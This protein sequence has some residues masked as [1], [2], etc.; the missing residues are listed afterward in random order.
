MRNIS[1][2]LIFL[3]SGINA[4]AQENTQSGIIISTNINDHFLIIDDDFENAVRITEPDTIFLDPGTYQFRI[5]SPLKN[6]FV[7]SENIS[8]N[9]F[10]IKQLNL[11][12]SNYDPQFSSYPLLYWDSNIIVFS[13][14]NADIYL[15][16]EKVGLTAVALKIPSG[17]V[18]LK[19]ENNSLSSIKNIYASN[20][21]LQVINLTTL[22]VKKK[23]LT[24]SFIPG[25]SQFYK[26]QK[27]KGGLLAAGFLSF[28]TTSIIFN[29]KFND[30]ENDY[31]VFRTFY[32]S[33][34]DPSDVLRYARLAEESLDDSEKYYK[35]RNLALLGTGVI[36]LYN[37]LDGLLSE[38]SQGYYKPWNFDPYFQFSND[39]LD[40]Y[41]ITVTR[42]F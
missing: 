29:Q 19:A 30:A 11:H 15:N 37:V 25:G 39:A 4:F 6:D 16:G 12:S 17:I 24:L 28:V 34:S 42:K 38:P 18:S 23:A 10:L 33:S 5:A 1:F 27:I 31:D 14:E 21:S 20:R 22:P 13:E 9:E 35:Q 40:F 3:F 32:Q 8:P 7:F 2:L 41:G 36:Y 26:Q